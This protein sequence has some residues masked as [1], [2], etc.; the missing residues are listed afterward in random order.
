MYSNQ[1]LFLTIIFLI[2]PFLYFVCSSLP[3]RFILENGLYYTGLALQPASLCP[4]CNGGLFTSDFLYVPVD[5]CP[6]FAPSSLQHLSCSR[7]FCS[8]TLGCGSDSPWRPWRGIWLLQP[9][10]CSPTVHLVDRVFGQQGAQLPRHFNLSFSL[11]KT[12][13]FLGFRLGWVTVTTWE[14]QS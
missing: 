4:V 12:S 5:S 7:S 8:Q 13:R 6:E 11:L 10:L 3:F 2:G 1:P 9:A 14:L